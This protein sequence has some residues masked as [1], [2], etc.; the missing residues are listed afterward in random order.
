MFYISSDLLYI[1][2]YPILPEGT[3]PESSALLCHQSEPHVLPTKPIAAIRSNDDINP[4]PVLIRYHAQ[5]NSRTKGILLSCHE[6]LI[7]C[8]KSLVSEMFQPGVKH[9][10]CN[11]CAIIWYAAHMHIIEATEII[12]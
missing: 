1:S 8:C 2:Q 6:S 5:N 10:E 7:S 9:G 11:D 3:H 4:H 12:S